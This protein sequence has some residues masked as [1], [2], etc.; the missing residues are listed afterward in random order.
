MP[1]AIILDLFRVVFYKELPQ[2]K[3]KLYQIST[4]DVMQGNVYVY[5]KVFNVV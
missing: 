3:S 5:A 2:L 1:E 4:S